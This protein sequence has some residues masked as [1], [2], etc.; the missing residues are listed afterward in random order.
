MPVLSK[1][2]N[3]I[4]FDIVGNNEAS[5]QKEQKSFVTKLTTLYREL[6]DQLLNYVMTNIY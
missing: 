5:L 3:I 4:K 6:P 1:C 2:I